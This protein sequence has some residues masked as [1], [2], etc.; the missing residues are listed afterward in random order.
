M[1]KTLKS[2]DYLTKDYEGFRKLMIDLIPSKTPEWTDTSQTDMG[3]V[4]IELLAHGLDVLSYYQDKMFTEAFLPTART[5]KAVI[6]LC[7]MLGY[8]LST[9]VPARY[10]LTFTKSSEYIDDVITIPKG[11]KVGTD[12]NNGAPV[13]YETEDELIIPAGTDKGYVNVTH[14]ITIPRDI[15]GAGN[16]TENQKF[17]LANA[18]VLVDTLLVTTQI[19]TTNPNANNSGFMEAG[20]SVWSRVEDF[21][22]S[23]TEDR[24]FI[25]IVDEFNNTY[26]E[27]GNGRSGMR[28]P[29]NV[30][31]V[32]S[33]RIGGGKIGNVGLRTINTL[34]ETEIAGLASI[35]NDEQALQIGQDSEDIEHARFSA[36]KQYR[37]QG[38]CITPQDFEDV[39]T[40]FAG[41]ARAKVVESFNLNSDIYIYLVP[42]DYGDTVPQS[43]KDALLEEINAKKLIHDNP[44]LRD[45]TYLDFD[46]DVSVQAYGNFINSTVKNDVTTQI[47]EAF[48]ISNMEYDEDILVSGIYRELLLVA[49]VRNVVINS[50]TADIIAHDNENNIPRLCRLRNVTVTV[51]GG[52]ELE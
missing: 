3:I 44:I 39:A 21:L 22:G 6:N 16:N 27:F 12:P 38:Q 36:P 29:D 32:T 47:E 52:V 10:K 4:L 46:I 51:T 23:G 7:R 5:R 49:G 31:V 37:T 48:A 41:I 40:T 15:V 43:T 8:E 26:I 13:V 20:T 30:N 28:V 50:P 11:T 42:D 17:K 18:D 34:I 33:Y 25:T 35:S 14:G 2:V 19:K 1:R 9:Q 24:H 45:P